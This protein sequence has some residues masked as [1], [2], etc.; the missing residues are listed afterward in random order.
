MDRKTYMRDVYSKYWLSARE[1]EYGFLNY[2]KALCSYI[3]QNIKHGERILE[4]AIGTGFPFA[5]YFQK[6][7]Y[8]VHGIDIAP[9]LIEKCKKLNNK[10]ICKI[11]DA[12]NLEYKNNYFKCVYCFHSTF[13]FTNINKVIEEMLRTVT[14]NG[15]VIFDIQNR[16]NKEV[17]DGFNKIKSNKSDGLKKLLRY[18]KNIIKILLRKGTP[19][20]TNIVHEI[21]IYPETLFEYFKKKKINYSI[22]AQSDEES[23][24]EIKKEIGPFKNFPRLVIV[25]WK[26]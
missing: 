25:I 11:G 7:G 5:D 10:I 22:M 21:P 17:V 24:F 15:M 12:E 9:I 14:S 8:E 13:Y 19:D 26:Q 16:N 4:V 23:G 18:G 1:K 3:T 2:D 6:K 20:W